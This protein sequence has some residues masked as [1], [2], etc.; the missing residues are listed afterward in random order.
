M[1]DQT[2][3]MPPN[4]PQQ[5]AGV[6]QGATP[7]PAGQGGPPPAGQGGPMPAGQGGAPVG[8]PPPG[9]PGWTQAGT[10]NPPGAG[11]Y[12]AGPGGAG[13]VPPGD[14]ARRPG[15]WKQATSTTGGK[16]ATTIAFVL[17]GLLLLGV[18]ATSIFAIARFADRGEPGR[19]NIA[20]L[21]EGMRDG[22]P[23]LRQR[24]N[25]QGNGGKLRGDGVFPGL[26]MLGTMGRVQHGE[27]TA[28]GTD[29]SPVVLLVQ[30]GTVTSASATSVAVRSADGFAQTYAVNSSTRLSGGS[31]AS[32]VAGDE[33]VVVARK[34]GRVALQIVQVRGAR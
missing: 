15:L 14:A 29:G 25:G 31:A 27:F 23:G 2:Q 6:P 21:R 3:P 28:T 5:P 16:V 9:A 13:Q 12:A 22:M 32:L 33:V 1:P 7:P 26:G 11:A 24:G 17:A 10:G 4:Q 19:E 20:Q 30:R 8:Q 34:E 18:M